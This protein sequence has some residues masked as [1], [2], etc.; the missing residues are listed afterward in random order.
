MKSKS[1]FEIQ[2]KNF[3]QE[4]KLKEQNTFRFMTVKKSLDLY[5]NLK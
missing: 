1:V 3:L 5:L 2:K 4:K